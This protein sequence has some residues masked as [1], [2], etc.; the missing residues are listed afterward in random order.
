[1]K[2]PSKVKRYC[3][4]CRKST[5]QEIKQAGRGGKRG[6]LKSGQRQ[7][8]AKVVGGHGDKGR[9]SKKPPKDR[10]RASK[11]NKRYDFRYKCKE[12]GKQSVQRRGKRLKRVEFTK[13]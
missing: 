5:L 2:I 12:C 6:S 1:M 13:E 9:Y 7:R 10:K 4:K 8:K 3:P 11:S